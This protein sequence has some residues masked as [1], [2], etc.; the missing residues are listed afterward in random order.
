MVGFYCKVFGLPL[1]ASK[2]YALLVFDF[3]RKGLSFDDMVC[4]LSA[5]KSSVSTSLNILI[6]NKFI[7][8][9]NKIDER[10][11]YFVINENFLEIR[12]QEILDRIKEEEI[13]ATALIDFQKKNNY[14][15][16]HKCSI[17][18]EMLSKNK[19]NI[20]QSLKKLSQE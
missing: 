10:K 11:R 1:L 14:K 18:I 20:E 8:D 12:F 17:Y 2:I 4:G 7:R 5:S 15:T 3:E 9:I 13:L 6:S 16:K 19:Q